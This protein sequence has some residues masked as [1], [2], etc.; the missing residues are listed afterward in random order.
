MLALFS[1]PG[2]LPWLN[3]GGETY[4]FL[5]SVWHFLNL[6]INVGPHVEGRE[7]EKRGGEKHTQRQRQLPKKKIQQILL[8]IYRVP[9]ISP[10]GQTGDHMVGN[11]LDMIFLFTDGQ[12]CR[13]YLSEYKNT[14]M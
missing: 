12:Y 11:M 3:E 13:S 8:S 10:V 14:Q 6:E 4:E 7:R 2:K 5:R 1:Q 9:C